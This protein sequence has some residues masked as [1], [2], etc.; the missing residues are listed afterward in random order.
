MACQKLR[1]RDILLEIIGT[2]EFHA[3]YWESLKD[4]NQP[5]PLA[6]DKLPVR[7]NINMLPYQA[8]VKSA[9][10]LRVLLVTARPSG[11]RYVNSRMISRPLV[12]ALETGKVAATIDIV[13]PRSFKKLFKHLEKTRDEHGDGYYH[14]LYL[15]MHGSMLTYKKYQ[16]FAK[17]KSEPSLHLFRSGDYA[18]K[19]VEEYIGHRAYLLFEDDESTGQ[20]GGILVSAEVLGQLLS[21]R[22][23]PMV[24]LN[25]CQSNKQIGVTESSLVSRLFSTGVQIVITMGYSVTVSVVQLLMTTLYE[26]LLN[27]RELVVAFVEP[28]LGCM[29]T[30]IVS[31]LQNLTVSKCLIVASPDI[32]DMFY[33]Y[34]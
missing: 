16:D 19:P 20:T 21:M 1:K 24:D 29:T 8:E 5:R 27:G 28:N 3:L 30:N 10:Q 18:Q 33:A 15:D 26:H 31:L 9:P 32:R 17:S 22:Q 7:K 34:I 14:M 2:P 11:K 23:I 25:T 4:P 13:R 6:V 12:D